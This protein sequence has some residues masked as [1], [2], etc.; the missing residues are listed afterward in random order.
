MTTYK[1]TDELGTY[2]YKDEA[3]TILHNE[4][5]HAIILMDGTKKYYEDGQQHRKDGPS[6]EFPNN[7]KCWCWKGMPLFEE[8]YWEIA[9][10]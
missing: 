8:W 10:K 5:G 1:R 4:D 9:N 3:L 7:V 2:F 6:V